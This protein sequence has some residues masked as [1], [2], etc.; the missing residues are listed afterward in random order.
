MTAQ[1]DVHSAAYQLKCSLWLAVSVCLVRGVY[2]PNNL[3]PTVSP[4]EPITFFQPYE[5][6]PT[7]R[8]TSVRYWFSDVWFSYYLDF[9]GGFLV[10]IAEL[11]TKLC[12]RGRT[13][14]AFW[15]QLVVT[16]YDIATFR[17]YVF[18]KKNK[19]RAICIIFM[20]LT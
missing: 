12:R 8:Y 19:R 15:I 17:F 11:K 5:R 20:K 7:P 3:K 4:S 10:T 2:S 9:L 13:R 14:S 18:V 6:A 1:V 16:I